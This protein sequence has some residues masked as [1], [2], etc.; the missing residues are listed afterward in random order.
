MVGP[1]C[2]VMVVSWTSLKPSPW[3]FRLLGLPRPQRPKYHAPSPWRFPRWSLSWPESCFLS[4]FL[5]AFPIPQP[6]SPS[7]VR[8][9]AGFAWLRMEI[10]AWWPIRFFLDKCVWLLVLF[11]H[12][13]CSRQPS[14]FMTQQDF[15]PKHQGCRWH[16]DLH[17]LS[18]EGG[19]EEVG[20][21]GLTLYSGP[22]LTHPCFPA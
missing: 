2:S 12:K 10:P 15:V 11:S 5:S 22:A 19:R 4:G 17:T 6:R 9:P 16:L 14:H 18:A 8:S 3:Y 21:P 20:M 7:P 13:S 1:A